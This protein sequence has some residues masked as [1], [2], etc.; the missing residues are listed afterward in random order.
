MAHRT[1]PEAKM[2]LSLLEE[3][4]EKKAWHGPNLKGSLR[5]LTP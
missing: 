3:G 2:L 5:G 4:Y 1:S